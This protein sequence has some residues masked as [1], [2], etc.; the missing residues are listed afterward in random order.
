MIPLGVSRLF[1]QGQQ[2][3]NQ[4]LAQAAYSKGLASK[5]AN[6]GSVRPQSPEEIRQVQAANEQLRKIITPSETPTDDFV[7]RLSKYNSQNALRAELSLWSTGNN[8]LSPIDNQAFNTL[9]RIANDNNINVFSS[10]AD[11]ENSNIADDAKTILSQIEKDSKPTSNGW[12]LNDKYIGKTVFVKNPT[13]GDAFLVLPHEV[14]HIV[15]EHS[16]PKNPDYDFLIQNPSVKEVEANLLGYALANHINPRNRAKHLA[17]F[18]DQQ[19]LNDFVLS[20][21]DSEYKVA[22]E[23]GG[24]SAKYLSQHLQKYSN[25]KI[26]NEVKRFLGSNYEPPLATI[27]PQLFGNE[28]N[29]NPRTA[30]ILQQTTPAQEQAFIEAEKMIPLGTS[31]LLPQGQAIKQQQLA[32]AALIAINGNL[33]PAPA[34]LRAADMP[35]DPAPT[36]AKSPYENMQ[37]VARSHQQTQQLRGMRGNNDYPELSP[38]AVV[39]ISNKPYNMGLGEAIGDPSRPEYVAAMQSKVDE[40]AQKVAH[41]AYKLYKDYEST[42][43]NLDTFEQKLQSSD[44]SP[45]QK[46]MLA[47]MRNQAANKIRNLEG[48]INSVS[49]KYGSNPFFANAAP[50]TP[51]V[52]VPPS[53]SV[54]QT[55]VDTPVVTSAPSFKDQGMSEDDYYDM[56]YQR[57]KSLNDDQDLLPMGAQGKYF[58]DMRSKMQTQNNIVKNAAIAGGVGLTAAAATGLINNAL[59]SEP[60]ATPIAPSKKA[61]FVIDKT[62][63]TAQSFID[64]GQGLQPYKAMSIDEARSAYSKAKNAGWGVSFE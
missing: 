36:F 58:D 23:L 19:A 26:N 7:D 27:V 63:G 44:Y 16:N 41:P 43:R 47:D 21:R 49:Q 8:R 46:R 34:R 39:E 13:K 31:R 9:K 1:T 4:R 35:P 53:Q 55:V 54:K 14:A 38:I 56:E 3:G 32:D 25:A 17:L 10:R 52:V 30:P 6:Y 5:G 33:N 2:V 15:R 51:T 45:E 18:T 12:A 40:V 59:N 37:S 48:S 57:L 28:R 50:E 24:T 22:D 62:N 20:A 60:I 64:Q 61:H 42:K 11:I 29:S